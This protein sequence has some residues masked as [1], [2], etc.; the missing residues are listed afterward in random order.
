MVWSVR[1]ALGKNVDV[2][3]V[4]QAAHSNFGT[5]D[6][7]SA[8]KMREALHLIRRQAPELEVDGEMHGDMALDACRLAAA[9]PESPLTGEANLLV[10]P[11]IDAAN[12]A[13]SLLKTTVGNG[14]A[15]GPILLGCSRAVHVLTPAAT[16]RRIVNMTALCVMDAVSSGLDQRLGGNEPGATGFKPN[17]ARGSTGL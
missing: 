2:H 5:S 17:R 8:R 7:A 15:V 10:M 16:V 13:Y 4:R 12:I 1:I 9:M 3:Q 11:N 6:S 14:I